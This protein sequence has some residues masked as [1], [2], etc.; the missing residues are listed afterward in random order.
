MNGTED[1]I[2][3]ACRLIAQAHEIL[4]MAGAEMVGRN[5]ERDAELRELSER[6]SELE[7]DLCKF[8]FRMMKEV[9]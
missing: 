9:A 3:N 8:G 4:S 5:P 7:C 6:L 2:E 1:R